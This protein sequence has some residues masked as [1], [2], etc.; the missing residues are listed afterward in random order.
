MSN[1]TYINGVNQSAIIRIDVKY[2]LDT[3]VDQKVTVY[4][5]KQSEH[6]SNFSIC[7]YFGVAEYNHKE[8]K[9]FIGKKDVTNEVT[10]YGFYP[11][12]K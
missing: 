6:S 5:Q 9:L 7:E 2:L 12:K 4:K 8:K 11:P 10:H 1:E 3:E